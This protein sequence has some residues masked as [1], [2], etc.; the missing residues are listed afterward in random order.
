MENLIHNAI[1]QWSASYNRY[2][3]LK[4]STTLY[5]NIKFSASMEFKRLIMIWKKLCLLKQNQKLSKSL[6]LPLKIKYLRDLQ[7]IKTCSQTL[8][9]GHHHRDL[10]PILS[11]KHPMKQIKQFHLLIVRIQVGKLMFVNSKGNTQ[12]MDLIVMLY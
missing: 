11:T 2:L 4:M 1:K 7:I 9:L 12:I 3:Q 10:T 5:H 8:E 6:L